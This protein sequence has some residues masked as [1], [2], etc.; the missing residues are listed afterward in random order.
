[1]WADDQNLRDALRTELIEWTPPPLNGGLSEVLR[2]GRRRRRARQASVALTLV[3]AIA[4]AVFVVSTLGSPNAVPRCS[5][6]DTMDGTGQRAFLH[7][8]VRR[9]PTRRGWRAGVPSEPFVSLTQ[10]LAPNVSA[11]AGKPCRSPK[12]NW[13]TSVSR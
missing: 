10:T 6:P 9:R 7:R 5:I 11:R 8:H 13:P 4:G 12:F 2:L 1:M 3:A